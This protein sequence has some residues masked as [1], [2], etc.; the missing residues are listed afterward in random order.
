MKER[1]YQGIIV[2]MLLFFTVFIVI[3][4]HFDNENTKAF[5]EMCEVVDKQRE[6]NAK[7]VEKWK[8]SYEN[9]QSEYG[10]CLVQKAQLEE[11][12]DSVV[13]PEYNF[14]EAEIYLLAQCVEAEA[15]EFSIAEKSQ[16]YIAQVILNRVESGS[17]PNTIEEVV[18][19]KCGNIPQFSVAY[20]G[21]L[22]KTVPSADTME[23]VYKVLVHGTDLPSYVQYFY[24][25]YVKENWVNTLNTYDTVEGTVFAY[26]TKEE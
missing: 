18:Y 5:D 4:G 19:Q 20:N 2:F 25:A 22:D 23:N 1:M 10:E 3:D 24:S 9:L 6:D 13:L 21:M 17:F 7:V 8:T 15:G 14:S 11:K 26:Y 12:L 16:Q